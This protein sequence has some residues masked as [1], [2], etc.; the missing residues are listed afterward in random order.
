MFALNKS[1]TIYKISK[2]FLIGVSSLAL[3]FHIAVLYGAVPYTV[4]WGGR[5]K[6]ESELYVFESVSTAVNLAFLFVV[7]VKVGILRVSAS[8]KTINAALYVASFIFAANTVGNLFSLNDFE[9]AV[10]TPITFLLSVF[11]F[12]LARVE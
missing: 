2:V 1:S 10:F 8:A 7:S 12:V 5:I 3:L 11:S 9:R 6:D 4:V